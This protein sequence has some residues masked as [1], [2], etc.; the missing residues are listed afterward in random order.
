M[1]TILGDE[2]RNRVARYL[3][4]DD[5]LQQLRHWLRS[6]AL[7]A[8]AAMDDSNDERLVYAVELLIAE[9]EHGD[10]TEDELRTMLKA[11]TATQTAAT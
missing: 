10:W 3:A 9:L 2:T 6:S 11:L 8:A 4:R 1:G 7:T 5:T